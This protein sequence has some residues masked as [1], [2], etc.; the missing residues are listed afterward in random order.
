MLQLHCISNDI[1][2]VAEFGGSLVGLICLES[3]L[4]HYYLKV[5]F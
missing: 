3:G 4:K 1:I 2:S 5:L